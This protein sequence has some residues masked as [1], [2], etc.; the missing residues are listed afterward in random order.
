MSLLEL[1]YNGVET[2][3]FRDTTSYH[4]KHPV[5][6]MDGIFFCKAGVLHTFYK[7]VLQI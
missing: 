1:A 3:A 2:M 5:L 4:T 7:Y 6:G